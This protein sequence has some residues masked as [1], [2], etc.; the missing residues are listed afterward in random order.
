[1]SNRI[2]M[3]KHFC[4]KKQTMGEGQAV[5]DVNKELQEYKPI[6]LEQEG[7]N[8][9]KEVPE[10]MGHF[11]KTL[12][13]VGKEQF[14][15]S[16]QLEEIFSLLEEEKEQDAE[17]KKVRQELEMKEQEK[18]ALLQLILE[19]A[20]SLEEIHRYALRSGEKAWRE[21]LVLQ[22]QKT[23][24]QMEKLGIQR[25]KGAGSIFDPQLHAAAEVKEYPGVPHGLILDELKSGY[26]YGEK[27][28]R[29]AE[30]V[31]NRLQE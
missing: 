11:S 25:L 23:G 31:V 20:D 10:I 17:N 24:E 14:K 19:M 29:K 13:R 8:P 1:L 16:R 5:L 22:W 4:A 3:I 15:V 12:E 26:C 9:R 6:D 18:E 7:A 21:Q 2:E 28:I 30:V 27:I